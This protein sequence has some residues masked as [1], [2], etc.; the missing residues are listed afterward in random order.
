MLTFMLSTNR[1]DVGSAG[2]VSLSSECVFVSCFKTI[3]LSA[4]SLL[5]LKCS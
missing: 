5:R 1:G 3:Q 2:S 4:G